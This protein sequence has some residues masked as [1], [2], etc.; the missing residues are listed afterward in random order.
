ML[1][2]YIK[3]A[4]R[5]LFRNK[6]YSF[7][8]IAGL[9]IGIA[10]CVLILF[11]VQ[12]E[13][14]F[15]RFHE[16][17]DNIYRLVPTF[18]TSERTMY[19]ATNAHVQGPMLK[20]EFPEVLNYVRFTSYGSRKS[21]Q[22]KEMTFN[23][24]KFLWADDTLFD[25]FS[26][27]LVKG[28]PKD[29]LVKP[30]SLVITEEMAEKYFGDEDPMGKTLLVNND[31]LY[32][33]T[34]MM[35]N[36][37]KTS[38]M[39]P[40]FFASF[41]T[42]DLKPTGNTTQDLLMQI[43]Y[44]TY[45]LLRDGADYEDLEQRFTES[46]NTHIGAFLKNVGGSAELEL[47][48]LKSI[49]LH[50]DRED[51]I[52]R[53]GDIAYVYLFSGIGLFILLL[54]CL[55]F[56]NLSTARSANRAKEVGLRKVVGAL[57]SQLIK[58]FL[59]E[60][61]ILTLIAVIFS[62]ILVFFSMPVFKSISGKDLGMDYFSNPVLLAGLFGLF[63]IVSLIGG[64]YP[65]FFL[66]AFRPVEVIQGKLKRGA[67]S[68]VLRIALV[69]LQFTVSIVLIIG[70]LIVSQQL[71]YVKNRK[72]GYDKDHVV[73]FRMRN[74]ETQRKYEAIKNDLIQHP[75]ILDVSASTT[76]PLGASDFSVHH[77]V[78]KP[79]DEIIMLFAQIVDED[80]IGTY[81]MEIVQGRN[82]SKEFPTDPEE[83]IIINEAAVNKLGWQDIAIGKQ[84][85]RFTSLT[86]RRK[87]RIVGI[88][89]DYH[90][91]SL[92][93]EI[94]PLVL[95]NRA[96]YDFSYNRMSVRVKPENIQETIGFLKSKW[97]EFDSQYP[98][99]YAFV[100]DQYDELYRAEERLGQ[101]FGYF[102][103]LAIVIGCLGLFGLTSF[104]AEQRTKEIGIRKVLGASV[105]G[106]VWMLVREFTKWVLLAV[107]IAWPVGY[108]VMNSWL[109]N[110]F[111][112]INVGFDT[113]ILAA[114][115]ALIIA[116]ITVSYQ[117]VKAALANPVDSLKYE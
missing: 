78:G 42:L 97:K 96:P 5:N 25:V 52:E 27:K 21:I 102:T 11:Y 116:I 59:G 108:L 89:K 106:V 101:L 24:E 17:S 6:L 68:S 91:Q 76:I 44:Y 57:R 75:S 10:C 104:A 98:F 117:A 20:S 110:F 34:G 29:A 37:P 46:L 81:K 113:L 60:S 58:Q 88:V 47:Q 28:S 94:Q 66:S 36:V 103:A 84:I 95:F 82:F 40:D 39:R 100:D 23:E 51:E 49:Y 61:M 87:Y 8:N 56:M 48:P 64:S 4:L 14:S 30:N 79:E 33:V 77:P 19:M 26:F 70:T 62:L 83:A 31:A 92:H 63:V 41:S 43:N 114:L 50:S 73:S 80:F 69:S 109:Q 74:P 86:T 90:F 85:E 1:K 38:H 45:L 107:L 12:D 22:Y 99:E 18:T 105:Q 65:A 67:K 72:L 9:A 15:D 16:N 13:L 53:T 35:E 32:M 115:L 71:N 54:A 55:N 111:Y 3:T 93:R 2:N 7:L 112:R